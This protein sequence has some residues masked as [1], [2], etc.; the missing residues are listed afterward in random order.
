MWILW[1]EKNDDHPGWFV[2]PFD[3][4]LY[5]PQTLACWVINQLTY[6]AY[7]G[8][9]TVNHMLRWVQHSNIPPTLVGG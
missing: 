9:G 3:S 1:S 7:L 4:S 2:S 8:Y 6:L 5:L